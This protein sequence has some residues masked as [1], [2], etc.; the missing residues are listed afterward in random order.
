MLAT[1]TLLPILK[2]FAKPYKIDIETRDISVSGRILSQFTEA[3]DNLAYLGE[4]CKLPDST[5]IKLPN[6]SASIPQLQAAI[7]ELQ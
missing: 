6:I 2:K 1:Y 7:K 4:L 3:E 5:V